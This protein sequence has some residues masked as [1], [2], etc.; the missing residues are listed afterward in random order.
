MADFAVSPPDQ[1][2]RPVRAMPW[3]RR[4]AQAMLYG[5][6]VDRDRKAKA[7]LRPPPRP[8]RPLHRPPPARAVLAF[9]VIYGLI[10]SKLVIFAI[11]PDSDA[12]R[13]GVSGDG[14]APARPDILDR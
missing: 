11:A 12:A 7:P 9:V 8:P 5:R 2:A 14:V 10:A 1:D 3:H 6:D 4:L 13:R